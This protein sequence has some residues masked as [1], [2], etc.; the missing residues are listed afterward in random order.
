MPYF[1]EFKPS[2]S[3]SS[4]VKI[5][6][7]VMSKLLEGKS[8]KLQEFRPGDLIQGVVVKIGKNEVLVDVGAKSEAILATSEL[9]GENE[10]KD[11]KVGD[12]MV[13]K[14]AQAENDQGYIVLSVKRAE[15]ERKWKEAEEAFETGMPL[16]A[17]VIEYNKG[18]LLCDCAGLRGFI[19]L[20]HLDR[21]HFTNDVAKFAAGSEAELKES[22][23][24]LAGKTL[25]VKV[26]ELDVEKNRFVLSEKEALDTYSQTARQE[27]L[28]DITIG[29]KMEGVVT[30][31]MPFGIFV[32]LGGVEGLVHISEIAWEK[33]NHPTDYFTVGQLV[34]VQVL[35]VDDVSKKL[36]LSVKRLTTNPWETVDSKYT[37]GDKIKGIVSKIVPFGAFV[38]LEKGLD[39]LIHISEADGPLT[40]GQEIEAVITQV[41]GAN[42]KL[43][44]SIKQLSA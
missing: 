19:P 10:F 31:I 9:I 5:D 42:Q 34:K 32:D 44:L 16:E 14:V 21:V 38:T 3:K 23:K 35:G 8:I 37:V 17:T 11:L 18:G 12:I 25:K 43:A 15:K 4:K 2:V 33:V 6:S 1:L 41:D 40:E 26:I 28:S 24:V 30:G 36:A 13:A 27:K 20:S 7:S 39:G 29:D 22:L